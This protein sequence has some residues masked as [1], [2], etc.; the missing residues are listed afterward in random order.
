[1]K[2]SFIIIAAI[3]LLAISFLLFTNIS[4][5][6]KGYGKAKFYLAD[7]VGPVL[8]VIKA[9]ARFADYVVENY[10]NLIDVKE[11]NTE[12]KKRL[13]AME[14]ENQK[15]PELQKENERLKGLLELVERQPNEMIASRIVGEDVTN[16]FKCIL[17][18]KGRYAGIR[19]KMPVITPLGVVGQAVEVNNWHT[20]VMVINDTNSAVDVFVT[21][22]NTR[23]IAEGTG[24]TTLKLKYVLKNDELE[25]GDK[26]ITSGKD[27]IFPK[28]LAVGI[29]ISVNKNMPG[30]F[31]DIDVMPFNNFKKLDE[32]LVVKK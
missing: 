16:W 1:V 2:G 29:V 24:Q 18:D 15:I 28:G 27:A 31:S 17:I 32:V 21:G 9:P 3:L 5:F 4:I 14:L 8:Q 11:R 23:G 19:E 22:K 10:V 30:L 20:K 12:L 25:V 7:G 26:L 6:Q 13:D